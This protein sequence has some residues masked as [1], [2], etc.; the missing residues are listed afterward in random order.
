MKI[1]ALTLFKRQHCN[2]VPSK[3]ILLAAWHWK[4]SLTW[5]WHLSWS[6]V[7]SCSMG[8]YFARTYSYRRGFNF[9]AILNLPIIGGFKIE[10]QPNM[11]L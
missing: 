10:T 9:C 4:W 2:G 1:G 7:V 11:P 5:R 6:P 8:P 3:G